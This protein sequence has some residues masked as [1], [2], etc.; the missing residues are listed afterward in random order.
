MT[1]IYDFYKNPKQKDS[2]EKTRYHARVVT[3]RTITTD[4]LARKIHARCTVTTA[5]VKGVLASLSDVIVE[6]LK[7]GNRVYIDGLGYLQITLSCPE[8][9]NTDKT[10]AQSIH[11]KSVAFRPEVRLKEQLKDTHFQRAEAKAHS[12]E[13]TAEELERLLALYFQTHESIN[14]NEFEQLTGYTRTTASRRLKTLVQAGKLQNIGLYRFPVYKPT[15]G[16]FK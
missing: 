1:A 3:N 11:F 15:E 7:S 13:H 14:R 8:V 4:E 12:K 16:N 9:E 5:D 2:T 10:R 6:E